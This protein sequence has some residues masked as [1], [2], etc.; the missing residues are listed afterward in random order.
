MFFSGIANNNIIPFLSMHSN[1]CLTAGIAPVQIITL[2]AL[3]FKSSLALITSSASNSFAFFNLY[4]SIS[5][6][7]TFAPVS[8]ANYI[9]KRPETPQPK[10]KTVWF[11]LILINPKPLTPHARGSIIVASSYETLSGNK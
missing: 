7:I 8:L 5:V 2:S 10:T 3:T 6:A 9:F 11:F 1:A 4:S